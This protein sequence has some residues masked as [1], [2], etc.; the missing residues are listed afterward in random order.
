[1][2]PWGYLSIFVY[3][4]GLPSLFAGILYHNREGIIADQQLR[5]KSRGITRETNPHFHIRM[6][7]Q[8][9]YRFESRASSCCSQVVHS[10]VTATVLI[11][12][13]EFRTVCFNPSYS[14]G[15]WCSLC[16]SFPSLGLLSCS[17]QLLCFKLRKSRFAA[18]KCS[19]WQSLSSTN[20][21]LQLLSLSL[22]AS[23][24]LELQQFVHG[25]H[26]RV[27]CVARPLSAVSRTQ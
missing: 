13:H 8:E 6:R 1:M 4:I 23:F 16:E 7:Y 14:G 15:G 2:K 18:C 17:A 10:S 20:F 11:C 21:P 27:V 24:G 26:I 25:D 22:Y 19:H 3:T 5:E 9:L 12:V